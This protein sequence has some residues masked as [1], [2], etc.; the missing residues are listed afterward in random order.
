MVDR[1]LEGT[2]FIAFFFFFCLAAG[3]LLSV[4]PGVV[5]MI[6]GLFVFN[7]RVVLTGKWEHGFFSYVAVGA[8][9][10]GSIQINGDPDLK[11]NDSHAVLNGKPLNLTLSGK[12]VK[13]GDEIGSFNLGST[14]VLVFEAPSNFQFT[15]EDGQKIKLGQPLGNFGGVTSSSKA[16]R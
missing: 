6:R 13:K 3:E 2:L 4:N 5:K 15:V 8:T 12:S 9:N 11:T 1:V 14:I 10:V 7:E 16:R